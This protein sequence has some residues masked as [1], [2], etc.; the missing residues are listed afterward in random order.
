MGGVKHNSTYLKVYTNIYE[1]CVAVVAYRK[2][3][4]KQYKEYDTMK[5]FYAFLWFYCIDL[6]T[7]KQ[8]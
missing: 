1:E 5:S 7:S 3:G 2:P 8:R 6:E 4:R